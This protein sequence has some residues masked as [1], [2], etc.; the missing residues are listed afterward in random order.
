MYILLYM[1]DIDKNFT[2]IHFKTEH[3]FKISRN[4]GTILK[5]VL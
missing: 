1:R 4:T 3:G 5:V 2:E